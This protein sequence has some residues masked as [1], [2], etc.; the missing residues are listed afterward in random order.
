[1]SIGI[2]TGKQNLASAQLNRP[3]RPFDRVDTGR[4]PAAVGKYFPSRRIIQGN[5]VG[6]TACNSRVGRYPFGV[7]CDYDALVAELVCPCADQIRVV[8]GCAFKRWADIDANAVR[9]FLG[10]LRTSGQTKR[11]KV[12]GLSARAR[13]YY[14]QAFK[15]FC[16]EYF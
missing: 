6:A 13:N 16:C 11:R 2:H 14:V 7:N 12:A 5:F 10:Q 9:S 8:D 15:Q 3:D 1:M 4:I